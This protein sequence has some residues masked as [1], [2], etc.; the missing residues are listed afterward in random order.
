MKDEELQLIA[1]EFT[2]KKSNRRGRIFTIFVGR[3]G[4]LFE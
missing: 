4:R 3:I 2:W 1:I